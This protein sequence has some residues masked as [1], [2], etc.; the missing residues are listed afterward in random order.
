M[1][2]LVVVALVGGVS[3]GVVVWSRDGTV[4]GTATAGPMASA[5]CKTAVGRANA[6]LAGA[7][8]LRGIVAEQG[9]ILRDPANRGLSGRKVL[10]RVA[11]AL[12]AGSSESDRFSRVL[13]DYRQVVDQ[14][15]L[16]S[17]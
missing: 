5:A 7:V 17:P 8:R 11:P 14:C 13:A 2:L 1:G 15:K 10:A 4:G 3:V 9:R 16:Q 6:M 12:R